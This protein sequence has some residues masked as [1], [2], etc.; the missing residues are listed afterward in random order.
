MEV[1]LSWSGRFIGYR[2]G[3][4]YNK[5]IDHLDFLNNN[6]H[7][8]GNVPAPIFVIYILGELQYANTVVGS[9]IFDNEFVAELHQT[10]DAQIV[11]VS[12]DVQRIIVVQIDLSQ[13]NVLQN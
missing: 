4:K 12:H 1:D 6:R 2:V 10:V 11:G 8:D 5:Y 13:V 9:Q 3:F 7:D